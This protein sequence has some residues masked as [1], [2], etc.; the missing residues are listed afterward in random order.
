MLGTDID[1]PF[2]HM[3]PNLAETAIPINVKVDP[4][5]YLAVCPAPRKVIADTGAAVD[6]IGANDLHHKYKAK[7]LR[8]CALL[9]G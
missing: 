8:D 1:E 6:P 2:K 5:A 4:R 3:D 7:D 9:H